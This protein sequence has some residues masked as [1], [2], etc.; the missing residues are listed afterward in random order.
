MPK[1]VCTPRSG[2]FIDEPGF[3]NC[4]RGSITV[5]QNNRDFRVDEIEVRFF[6]SAGAGI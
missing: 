3:I 1:S 6:N 5:N 4:K 2:E